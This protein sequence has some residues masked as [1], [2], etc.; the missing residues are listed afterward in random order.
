MI[1]LAF[2]KYGYNFDGL[3]LLKCDSS[4][5]L[6][7]RINEITPLFEHIKDSIRDLYRDNND[8]YLRHVKEIIEDRIIYIY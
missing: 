1:N 2:K 3:V 7:D 4:S 6:K 8:G 5:S